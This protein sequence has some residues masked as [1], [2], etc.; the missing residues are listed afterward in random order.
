[1]KEAIFWIRKAA[2]Q[3]NIEAF[4]Q[5]GSYYENV[6][7]DWDGVDEEEEVEQDLEKAIFW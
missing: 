4:F 7:G 2:D 5:L 1:M 3:E 6:D